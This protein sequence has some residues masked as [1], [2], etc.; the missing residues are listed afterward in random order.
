MMKNIIS[1]SLWGDN[2]LY[3]EGAIHNIALAKKLYPNWICRFY[4]EPTTVPAHT[5]QRII[6]SGSELVFRYNNHGTL[7][8]MW[9]FEVMFDNEVDRF[10]IRDADS[11]IYI[12][13]VV[14]VDE[15]IDSGKSFHVMRD[16]QHHNISILGGMWG[17]MTSACGV[18][19]NAYE[20]EINN[21]NINTIKGVDQEFLNT[22]LWGGIRKDY[23]CHDRFKNYHG[24]DGNEYSFTIPLEGGYHVGCIEQDVTNTGENVY[25]EYM[26]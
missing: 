24:C 6:D 10:L 23:L 7:G 8:S 13:E 22:Y 14:A 16:H 9:R 17:G 26:V 15:W 20:Y 5:I 12:R 18:F 4:V 25:L 1:F 19:K 21:P 2:P 11:R 3:N